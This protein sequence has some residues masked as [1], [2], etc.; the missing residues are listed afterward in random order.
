MSFLPRPAALLLATTILRAVPARA[1]VPDVVPSLQTT[2]SSVTRSGDRTYDLVFGGIDNIEAGAVTTSSIASLVFDQASLRLQGSRIDNW[3]TRTANLLVLQLY[4]GVAAYGTFAHEFFG[5]YGHAIHAGL[6]PTLSLNF[7]NFGG[8]SEYQATYRT[9]ALTRQIIASAGPEVT[10]EEAYEA[11]QA[12]YS[13]HSVGSYIGLELLGGHIVDSFIYYE[14]ALSPFLDDPT[15]YVATAPGHDLQKSDPIAWAL[16]LTERY[17]FYKNVI[18][19][20]ATWVYVPKNP[21]AYIN[22]FI[23]DQGNRVKWATIAQLFDPTVL[24]GLYGIARYLVTGEPF[25]R[26]IMLG[27]PQFRVAPAIRANLGYLGAENYFDLFVVA[28]NLPPLSVYYR[29]GGNL[30]DSLR[31]GGIEIRDV[32]LSERVELAGQVDGWHD[33]LA[34]N[35]GGNIEEKITYRVTRH[36]GITEALG[37]KTVGGLMGKPVDAGPYGYVGLRLLLPEGSN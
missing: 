4:L 8:G 31:G 35:F 37:Y 26:P 15:T 36:L 11:T 20:N 23:L 9:P 13:G 14:T 29:T 2:A 30:Y 5:H 33:G 25:Y 22:K 27:V 12:M 17:G 21:N 3:G 28:G 10:E 16:A 24:S 34:R 19:G 32:R 7:P 18:P 1:D 6:H